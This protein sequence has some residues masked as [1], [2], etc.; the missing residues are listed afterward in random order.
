MDQK[1]EALH[2][3]KNF[4]E[5]PSGVTQVQTDSRVTEQTP[6]NKNMDAYSFSKLSIEEKAMQ[7]IIKSIR[8]QS[9]VNQLL[10]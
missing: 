9:D 5:M 10:G 4:I 2:S 7:N 3:L 6:Q 1:K 8:Y